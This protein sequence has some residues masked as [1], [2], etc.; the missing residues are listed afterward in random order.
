[1]CDNVVSRETM[2]ENVGATS[3]VASSSQI[4]ALIEQS[5]ASVTPPEA[6]PAPAP[7]S[8]YPDVDMSDPTMRL[9][10]EMRDKVRRARGVNTG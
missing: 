5:L 8:N 9:L 4:R 2:C 1:M 7:A 6:S 3:G 10:V